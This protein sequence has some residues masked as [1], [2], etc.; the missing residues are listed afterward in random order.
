[1]LMP[2]LSVTLIGVTIGLVAGISRGTPGRGTLQGL[3]A[4]WCGF[5]VG[6][7]VGVIMDALLGTGTWL[8]L[9]GHAGALT[10]AIVSFAAR[11]PSPETAEA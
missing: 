3:V 6:A 9:I 11:S 1:M 10:A 4:A 8:A 7:F 5:V 2:T